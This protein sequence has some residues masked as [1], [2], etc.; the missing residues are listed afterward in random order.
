MT[1]FNPDNEKHMDI[2]KETEQ[3]MREAEEQAIKDWKDKNP[4]Q[5]VPDD[6]PYI[7]DSTDEEDSK[8]D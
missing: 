3:A 6:Y 7:T 5:D 4:D 8:E 1:D 2:V